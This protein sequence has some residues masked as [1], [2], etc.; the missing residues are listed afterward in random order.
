VVLI[1]TKGRFRFQCE[2][3]CPRQYC[4]IA[5]MMARSFGTASQGNITRRRIRRHFLAA[6]GNRVMARGDPCRDHI[7]DREGFR[8]PSKYWSRLC[9]RSAASPVIVPDL[10]P[11]PADSPRAYRR[12]Y[13][14]VRELRVEPAACLAGGCSVHCQN[15]RGVDPPE[16]RGRWLCIACCR[17]SP[18]LVRRRI[19]PRF[20]W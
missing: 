11:S 3:Y 12:P 16:V 13:P 17:G 19:V 1:P 9:S 18:A 15:G 5:E 4:I 7:R 6:L 2:E 8:Q 10:R 14:Q 20:C